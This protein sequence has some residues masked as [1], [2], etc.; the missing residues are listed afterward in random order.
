ME[1]NQYT[2]SRITVTKKG[3]YALFCGGDFLFSVDEETYLRH[4]LKEGMTLD[5]E[6]LFSLRAAS[7]YFAAKNKALDYLG[8][9][10]HSRKELTDKLCRRFDR[11]TAL[12]AVEKMEELG[13]LDDG[14]YAEKLAEELLTRQGKSLRAAA[15][16]LAE[17]GVAR[18]IAAEVLEPY[19]E[20]GEQEALRALVDKKY[21]RKLAD[22]ANRDNVIAALARRGFSL[23]DVKAVLA[24]MNCDEQDFY[25]EI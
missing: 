5:R 6:E 18:D 14:R 8:L 7:D 13:L 16:K 4:H 12:L 9:R 25:E 11:E 20:K 15:Q 22:P 1:Q 19:K 2:I 24:D 10:D 23:G 3:R 21:R 17:K